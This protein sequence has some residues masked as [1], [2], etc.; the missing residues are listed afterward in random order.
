MN[1]RAD[2]SWFLQDGGQLLINETSH[3][4]FWLPFTYMWVYQKMELA[5][6]ISKLSTTPKNEGKSLFKDAFCYLM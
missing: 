2:L 6:R 5:A 3:E 4:I 1:A